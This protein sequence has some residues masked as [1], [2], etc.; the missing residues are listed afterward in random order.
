M[1]IDYIKNLH[2]NLI[3]E[4]EQ[5]IASAGAD[6][7]YLIEELTPE[8]AQFFFDKYQEGN[9]ESL[10]SSKDSKIT[11]VFQQLIQAKV[12]LVSTETTT[13]LVFSIQWL[14][15]PHLKIESLLHTYTLENKKLA[16]T[17]SYDKA[18]LLLIIKQGGTLK[19][20]L[21][22][23]Y[24]SL[25]LPHLFVDVSF[26]HTVS[27]GPLVFPQK[28]ACLSCYAG[29]IIQHWGDH[30]TP[31]RPQIQE[32]PELIAALI[33]TQLEIFQNM[34]TCPEL[35]EATWAFDVERLSAQKDPVYRLPW[36]EICYPESA[37]YGKGAFE[38]PWSG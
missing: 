25:S 3:L 2:W 31:D 24:M 7:L 19:E 20:N 13:P 10:Q 26:H 1:E 8:Q 29:K 30:P 28:T 38:L 5:L 14:G 23:N 11:Q 16:L 37:T 6:E 9:L 35:I 15:E 27:M 32:Q 12:F 4:N 21:D 36:C 34:G 22:A 18:D 33:K 17:K